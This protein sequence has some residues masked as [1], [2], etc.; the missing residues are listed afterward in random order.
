MPIAVPLQVFAVTDLLLPNARAAH[1]T[2]GTACGYVSGRARLGD[3]SGWRAN[4]DA[5]AIGAVRGAAV[6]PATGEICT[7]MSAAASRALA[8]GAASIGIVDTSCTILGMRVAGQTF[9]PPASAMGQIGDFFN[10]LAGQQGAAVATVEWW[11]VVH[12]AV[13]EDRATAASRSVWPEPMRALALEY[14]VATARVATLLELAARFAPFFQKP[15][16]EAHR[17]V[18]IPLGADE[19]RL[20]A[21]VER[22]YAFLLVLDAFW[23][24]HGVAVVPGAPGPQS[25]TAAM[26]AVARALLP[27]SMRQRAEGWALPIAARWRTEAQLAQF[28][29]M[30]HQ[31]ARSTSQQIAGVKDDPS[32]LRMKSQAI[33]A[34]ITF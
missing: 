19:V 22:F 34:G 30:I 20:R 14:V 9:R 8:Q 1:V 12:R 13:E 18:V 3:V 11:D 10:S 25:D 7:S 16:A 21:V 32:L 33:A 27:E 28:V 26:L 17:I 29:S 31:Q 6:L 5:A 2:M 15:L 23:P 4:L 24:T